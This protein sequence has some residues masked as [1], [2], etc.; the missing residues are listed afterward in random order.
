MYKSQK[1]QNRTRLFFQIKM[2]ARNQ[3]LVDF[4]NDRLPSIHT[5]VAALNEGNVDG[6]SDWDK[7]KT[8]DVLN[9]PA[10]LQMIREHKKKQQKNKAGKKSA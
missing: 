3:L 10:F 6:R 2:T 4:V 7:K 8:I 5:I 9:N 1:K